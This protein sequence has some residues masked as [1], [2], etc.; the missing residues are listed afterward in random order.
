MKRTLL[1]LAFLTLLLSAM[2]AV[3]RDMVV[4]EIGTGTW[5]QYCPGAAMGA[6]DLVENHHRAAIVENHNGDPYA[7]TFS[8][9]RNTYYS[10]NSFPTAYFDGANASIGGSNNTSLYPSYRTKVTNRLGIPSKYSIT[11]TGSHTG[12]VYN[13]AVT[14]TKMED[15][16]NTDIRLH[17]ALT[18]SG[19]SQNWQGQSHLEF[20]QRLMAPDQNGTTI[21]FSTVASQTVNLTFTALQA[22]NATEFEFIFFLQNNSTKEVLQGCKYSVNALENI[23]PV[24]DPTLDFG[25]I[26]LGDMSSQPITLHNWWSQD[27]NVDITVDNQDFFLFPQARDAYL[28]PFMED[29]VFDVFFTANTP[30]FNEANI[31]ITTDN[32]AYPTITIPITA[33]VTG[34]ANDDQNSTLNVSKILSIAPNPFIN[35]SA[36][37]YSLNQNDK[38]ELQIFNVKGAKVLSAPLNNQVAGEH[39]YIWSGKDSSG[40]LCPSGIYFCKMTVSGRTVS[41]QKLIKVK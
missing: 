13:V 35:Y 4:V 27:M 17:A 38:A 28:V 16:A 21:D 37:K 23:F 33:N 2:V 8:N 22:W 24:S 14:V 36:I 25:N 40:N 5:C 15:D 10:I 20:V 41:T 34:T 29:M 39:S 12:L 3:P 26:D 9:A 31:T 6:D 19:I 32:P 1:A 11:A 30:G 7:N 18:Q